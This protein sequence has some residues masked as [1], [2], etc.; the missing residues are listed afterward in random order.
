MIQP[1]RIV[2]RR[3]FLTLAVALPAILTAGLAARRQAPQVIAK[4]EGAV[5]E[6]FI[7][8]KSDRMW[9][10]NP[11]VTEFYGDAS[12]PA[13]AYVALRPTHALDEPDLLLY[14]ISGDLSGNEL[15]PQ[16]RL[17]GSFVPGNILALDTHGQRSGRLVLY[18]AAHRAIVDTSLVER[19]P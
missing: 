9:Q 12:D 5:A 14:W 7:M 8:K 1:L 6:R 11:I 3:L 2:H 17:L 4:P 19:L 18:S 15:P 13:A 16:A 10:N